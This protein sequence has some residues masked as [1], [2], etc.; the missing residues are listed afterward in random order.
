MARTDSNTLIPRDA[1]M[2]DALLERI[3]TALERIAPPLPEPAFPGARAYGWTGTGLVAMS[4]FRPLPLHLLTGIDM[5]R[6]TLLANTRRLA[7]GHAAHDALLWGAR[8][9]GKSALVKAVAGA[10][11]DEGQSLA[12]V[13][14]PSPALGTLPALF[15]TLADWNR[16]TV[17]FLDDLAFDQNGEAARTLRS[18]LEGGA[19]ARP[20]HVRLYVTSNRRHLLPRNLEEQA[21]A[22]NPRDVVDDN[23]ALA[24]RFGL[25]IGFHVVD[26][27]HYLAMI[28]GYARHLGLSFDPQDA[29]TWATQRGIRSGRVAWHYA[30]ELAGRAGKAIV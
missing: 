6:D 1:K 3:A 8:G 22:I 21:S 26:Q 17:V 29:L 15:R 20:P 23:L 16:P 18:S 19:H 25:S 11:Q 28:D 13:E 9:T 24:D 10:L 2:T 4:D 14:L 5:Q 30:V 7:Q 12:L 27:D